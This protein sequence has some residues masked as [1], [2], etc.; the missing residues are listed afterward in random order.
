M[1]VFQTGG[2]ASSGLDSSGGTFSTTIP[3]GVAPEPSIDNS[4]E[5]SLIPVAATATP[6]PSLSATPSTLSTTGGAALNTVSANPTVYSTG[7]QSQVNSIASLTSAIGQ[8]GFSLAN[9]LGSSSAP[10]A[11]STRV[12]TVGSTSAKS[13]NSNL[14]MFGLL[15]LAVV[16][17]IVIVDE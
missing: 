12:V 3:G 10:A 15:V 2:F 6:N 17:V 7:S 1:S 9:I 13:S 4:Y 8:W 14:I 16:A 5:N 11:P